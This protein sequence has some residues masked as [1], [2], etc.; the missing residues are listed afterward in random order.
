MSVL[1]TVGN[2]DLIEKI[3]EGGMGTVYKGKNRDTGAIVAIKVVATHIANNQ[4]LLKRF[5]Q[6]YNVARQ[7][8][9][10]NVVRALDY[11]STG[12]TP[13][14]VM[15]FVDGETIGQRIERDGPFQ[16]KEAIRLIAQVAQAL[17]RAHKE[18]LIH[19]DVKPDNI[20]ITRD[21]QAKLTDL[22]L[23]KEVEADL[24]L[25]RT[26]RGLGTP[27]F[28]APE[29][30]KNAKNAD[31]RCDIYSLGATLYMMVTGEMPF[32]NSGPLDAYLK[33]IECKFPA[34]R[35][36]VPALSERTDWAIRRA[37]SADPE[38]RPSSCRE[39][40]E[41]LTGRSTRKVTAAGSSPGSQQDVWYLVY[42]DEDGVNHT[43][44]GTT[45]GIVRSLKEG[46]LGDASNIRAS[47]TKSE[48]FEP[49]RAFPEFRHVVFTLGTSGPAAGSPAGDEAVTRP[50]PGGGQRRAAPPRPPDSSPPDR[51][52]ARSG[53]KADAPRI[54][55]DTG[56]GQGAWPLWLQILVLV[57]IV[58]ASALV[59]KF[60]LFR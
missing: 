38:D 37:M 32:Q 27:H 20:L 33:K 12:S 41:D 24:N 6:E 25:T 15:E 17:H 54:A 1:Q 43:V 53:Q 58:V 55:V 51:A 21:G 59:G 29:Q 26:G 44:K 28:M 60:L 23:V 18:K 9:H 10:P 2:Y 42:K 39:F 45:G 57:L 13:F 11:G 31:P 7:L 3:A 4:V 40:V 56:E 47:R 35:E 19:R 34:P 16:E 30:F 52:K 22:G 50:A 36:L 48:G 14:L 8:E 46:L 5:E 49:L